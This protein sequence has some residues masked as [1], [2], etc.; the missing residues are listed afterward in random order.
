MES[1]SEDSTGIKNT[2]KLTLKNL[3]LTRDDFTLRNLK[4]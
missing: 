4:F 1:C 3:S 2:K